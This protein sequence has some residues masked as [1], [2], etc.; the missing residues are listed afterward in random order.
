MAEQEEDEFGAF[1]K[2]QDSSIST[3]KGV[4]EKLSDEDSEVDDFEQ[5]IKKDAITEPKKETAKDS[6]MNI[7]W[8]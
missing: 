2:A 7:A 6:T 8:G 5:F 4:D 1:V 3:S